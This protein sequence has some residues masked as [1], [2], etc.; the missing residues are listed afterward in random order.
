MEKIKDKRNTKRLLVILCCCMAIPSFMYILKGNTIMNLTSS[1]SFF[2]NPSF[3][4]LT[5]DKIIGT[6]LFMGLWLGVGVLYFYLIKY[7][8]DIFPNWKSAIFIIVI[9]AILFMAILPMTST[10][11]F[12]YIGTRLE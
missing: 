9:I 11:V 5:L 8:K 1:F 4:I 2:I 7:E 6:I 3:Q 10:D 12:Y